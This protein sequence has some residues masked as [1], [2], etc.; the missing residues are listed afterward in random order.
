MEQSMSHRTVLRCSAIPPKHTEPK[1]AEGKSKTMMK[2]TKGRIADLI[3]MANMRGR[4]ARSPEEPPTNGELRDAL[5][6]LAQVVANQVQ[7][8]AQAPR[9]T[10][11]GERV[12]DFMRMN[13]PV[14]HGS[15]VD[16]NPQE[17][18]DEGGKVG[19]VHELEAM[20]YEYALKFVQLSK[21]APHLVADSRSRMNKFVMGVSDLVSEECRSA[22][23]IGDMDLSRLMTYAE[24]MEEEKLS[25][26]RGL[27]WGSS[28]AMS[29]LGPRLGS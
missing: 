10:T 1:D 8:G 17:F 13:P 15:K 16:E 24:Q 19:G 27:V 18:I 7:Q 22:M 23:L 28:F 21:Y 12:R 6:M 14:F 29:R 5:T 3:I 20:S 26:K 2:M 9:T 11:P 25:K 4:R